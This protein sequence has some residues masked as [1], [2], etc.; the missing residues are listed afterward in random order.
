LTASRNTRRK[1]VERLPLAGG[2]GA[3]VECV[4]AGML[5][6]AIYKPVRE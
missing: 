6:A 1:V 2:G 3:F 4:F 5:A